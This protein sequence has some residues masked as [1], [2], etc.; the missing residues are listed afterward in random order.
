VQGFGRNGHRE[1]SHGNKRGGYQAK[2]PQGPEEWVH[3]DA[4][5]MTEHQWSGSVELVTVTKTARLHK[6]QW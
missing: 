2:K 6:Q 3:S 5:G 1:R 4:A